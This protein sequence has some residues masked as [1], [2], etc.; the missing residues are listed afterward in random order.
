MPTLLEFFRAIVRGDNRSE[1][2]RL[3]E[4]LHD[5]ELDR[6]VHPLATGGVS[7]EAWAFARALD[8]LN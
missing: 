8:K 4:L 2:E 1:Y 5:P 7:V 3:S 6:G